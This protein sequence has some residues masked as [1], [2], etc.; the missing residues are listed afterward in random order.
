MLIGHLSKTSVLQHV[1]NPNESSPNQ[2][3][4]FDLPLIYNR[5]CVQI[6]NR[7]NQV[8]IF[9]PY[10][11]TVLD[12]ETAK[13]ARIEVL[14][15][16]WMRMTTD[17]IANINNLLCIIA[18]RQTNCQSACILCFDDINTIQIVSTLLQACGKA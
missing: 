15:V 6:F 14:V 8:P 3:H 17:K 12:S 1:K 5:A 4:P 2:N 11:I 7:K 16:L 9:S 13:F 18:E 10:N